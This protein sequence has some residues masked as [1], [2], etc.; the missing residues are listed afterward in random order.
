MR[1]LLYG[2]TGVRKIAVKAVVHTRRFHSSWCQFNCKTSRCLNGEVHTSSLEGTEGN[3]T[4]LCLWL[5]QKAFAHLRWA[6]MVIFLSVYFCWMAFSACLVYDLL[7]QMSRLI[8]AGILGFSFL[9]EALLVS[10]VRTQVDDVVFVISAHPLQKW[11]SRSSEDIQVHTWRI[12]D[13]LLL[14]YRLFRL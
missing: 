6:Q 7:L 5:C 3:S 8:F 10:A 1:C 9:Q 2:Y 12:S 14:K 4:Q 13:L 11:N